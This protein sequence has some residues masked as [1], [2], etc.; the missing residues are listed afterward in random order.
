MNATT[1]ALSEI[2][3]SSSRCLA[4]VQTGH[5][6]TEALVKLPTHLRP[7]VQ[8]VAWYA[9]RHWGLA[10]AWRDFALSRKPAKPWL[11]CHIALSLL[12]LD[13]AM[14]E[15]G[16]AKE[17]SPQTPLDKQCPRYTPHTLVDQA[18]HAVELAKLGKPASGLVNAVL[19]R[20]QRERHAFIK[21]VTNNAVAQWNHP[22]WWIR[23][24]KANY[25]AD[26]QNILRA[27]QTPPK[28]VLRVN[29]RRASIEAVMSELLAAG[30][31]CHALGENAISLEDSAVVTALPG[32]DQGHWS[33]QDLSAQ[34]A[35]PLL[36]IKNGQRVLDAC[37]APGGKTAHLL[38][39]ADIELT[40][41]DQDPMRL[42]RVADNL[43]R[44]RLMSDKVSLRVADARA[45]EQWWNGQPFDAILADVPC[46]ASGVVRRHPDIAWLRR[47][48]DVMQ[49]TRLQQEIL[50]ALWQTLAP[51]GRLLL[52]TCSVFQEEG[53]GQAQAML[54][55]HAD[56]KRLPAPGQILPCAANARAPGH[57]GFF[58][59]VFERKACNR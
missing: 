40:A 23:K 14:I 31:H 3:L 25:P 24:L 39:L 26:W 22:A 47:E 27:N 17:A 10:Q 56:A 12:L 18:V 37:A 32:F 45:I 48:S 34:R 8:S 35:A 33:V 44:L 7:A 1:A 16:Q 42:A 57:D 59:A 30:H 21:A 43:T 49:T 19:R 6:L 46:T 20:F 11:N 51:G 29:R 41:L 5:S 28:L 4:A 15:H 13:A 52:V 55:R 38:E 54:T 9:M 36:D 53:E 2:L 58:Y 50:D